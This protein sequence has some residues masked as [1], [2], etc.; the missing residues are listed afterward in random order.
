MESANS[1]TGLDTKNL[2]KGKMKRKRGLGE[3]YMGR[4]LDKRTKTYIPTERMQ[5]V[6]GNRC[7]CKAS[8]H[9]CRQIADVRREEIHKE[10]WSLSWE[11]KRV[12]VK[13][14]VESL[15]VKQSKT[16]QESRRKASLV[17]YLKDQGD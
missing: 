1:N 6:F 2:G 16:S 17:Y 11:Q 4:Q 7:D 9:R 3:S 13:T 12:F 14:A 5:K 10:T 8:H 15:A